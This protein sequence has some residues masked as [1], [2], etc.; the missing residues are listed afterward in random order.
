[1]LSVFNFMA[2]I[3]FYGFGAWVPTLLMAKG[4]QITTS[5]QYAFIIALA[6]PFGP[7][8][9]MLV[10]DR[11]ERKWQIVCSGIGIGTFMLL[12][13][14][15]TL[16]AA[17]IVFGVLVT[18]SN[19]WL[20]F[21]FHNYQAE[22]YPTRVRAR[23][24]GF[25]YA[26]GRLSAAL[27]RADDWVLPEDRGHDGGGLVHW[28]SDGDHGHHHWCLRPTHAEPPAG[29]DLALMAARISAG[30]QTWVTTVDGVDLSV[31]EW[32]DPDGPELLLVH[33]QAQC[34]LCFWPQLASILGQRC[35]VIAY[36]M[37]GTW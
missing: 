35:R 34:H 36:D 25:V 8:L 28:W 22:L 14:S 24:V 19:N 7:L 15:Q 2:T 37:R 9:G 18:L 13:A 26:W 32:G 30:K 3:G 17:V 1:M 27:R 31:R 5:L 11:M 10:A 29:R 4:I 6:N 16:P 21:T 20:S 33:G 12:F 23:G